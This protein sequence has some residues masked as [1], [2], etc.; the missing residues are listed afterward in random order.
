MP[1]WGLSA[2]KNAIKLV[3]LCTYRSFERLRARK[4]SSELPH[5]CTWGTE[6]SSRGHFY[7]FSPR[8][9]ISA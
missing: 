3:K 4:V 7:D 1:V 9:D 8:Y 6:M 5:W 2:E